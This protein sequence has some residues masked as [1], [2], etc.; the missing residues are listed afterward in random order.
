MIRKGQNFYRKYLVSNL[1][2]FKNQNVT[3]ILERYMFDGLNQ[4]E[5]LLLSNNSISH[6]DANSFASV[7][8]LLVLDL[9]I[10]KL[11]KIEKGTFAEFKRMNF[12]D[13]SKNKIATFEPFSF[14]NR[15]GTIILDG[16]F[17][18][19]YLKITFIGNAL[20]CDPSKFEW[21]LLYLTHNQIRVFLPAQPEIKCASPPEYS[22]K[23]LK[24][25]L[26]AKTNETMQAFNFGDISGNRNVLSQFLP[27]LT[28]SSGNNPA[29]F[30][31]LQ[32]LTQAMPSLKNIPGLNTL[33]PEGVNRAAGSLFDSNNPQLHALEKVFCYIKFR[34][35]FKKFS[36]LVH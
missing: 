18:R 33:L 28:G 9:S 36:L 19:T 15:I 20:D 31:F 8:G 22:G 17:F 7:E 13:I 11:Q 29:N 5:S 27:S 16:I 3:I 35:F 12:L 23:R 10:N 21:F 34:V 30:Q 2:F 6:L 14:K 4:L 25:L 1:I 26:M 24:D 32:A